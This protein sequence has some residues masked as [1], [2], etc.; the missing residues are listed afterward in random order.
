METGFF[1]D[2]KNDFLR[3]KYT[4]HFS[5]N[6]MNQSKRIESYS[7][8]NDDIKKVLL[9]LSSETTT[10]K[11]TISYSLLYCKRSREAYD[12]ERDDERRKT[13]VLFSVDK[14]LFVV[15][16]NTTGITLMCYVKRKK[17]KP[18]YTVCLSLPTRT[19]SKE[20]SVWDEW[21]DPQDKLK[22]KPTPPRST[23]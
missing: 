12:E 7:W 19:R 8:L 21:K 4:P 11:K 23:Q 14:Q 5:L 10:T 6:R 13:M 18:V 9:E 15:G 20:P 1:F 22:V 17:W 2:C 16:H 3:T